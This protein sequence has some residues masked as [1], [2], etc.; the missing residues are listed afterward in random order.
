V[1]LHLGRVEPEQAELLGHARSAT[2]PP[3]IERVRDRWIEVLNT[4]DW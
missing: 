4:L 3:A 1:S 2:T